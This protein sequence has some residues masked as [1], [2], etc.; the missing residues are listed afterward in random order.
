M[1]QKSASLFYKEE[2]YFVGA[3][4]FDLLISES[5]SIEAQVSEHPIE[6]GSVVSDH[7][8]ILPRKGSLVGLVTN[9]P[10]KTDAKLPDW[11]LEK[12]N[13]AGSPSILTQF[14]RQ[15]GFRQSS[16]SSD[17]FAQL[18]RPSTNRAATAWEKFVELVKTKEPVTISTGLEKPENVIV[19]KV[20]ASRDPDTG[21]A[22]KFQV[23]FQ[24]IRIVK[25]SEIQILAATAPLDPTTAAAKV[26]KGKVGGKQVNGTPRP[27]YSYNGAVKTTEITK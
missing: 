21:D 26:K 10:L 25:L 17:D 27:V 4:K 13:A 18:V 9:H 3:I 5:H 15:Y 6:D 7:V 11:F 1:G 23:E 20:S 16:L 24:E 22:Q 12:L 19:T 2:G 8:R 14:A